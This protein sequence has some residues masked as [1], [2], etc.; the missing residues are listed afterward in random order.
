MVQDCILQKTH[1]FP[2][3][4]K[5][6][7]T[8]MITQSTEIVQPKAV[9]TFIPDFTRPMV[10]SFTYN[11]HLGKIN[12]T[13]SDVVDASTFDARAITLQHSVNRAT[14]RTFTLSSES[15]TYSDNGYLIVVDLD[16]FDL[17]TLKSN[18]GLARDENDTYLTIAAFLI[19]DTNGYDVAP[20]TDGKAIL[21]DMFHF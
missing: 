1:S 14:Q 17:L 2:S 6:S 3:L 20:I 4:Q 11:Q 9:D 21:V 8:L 5:H 16:H 10:L 12:L 19:D 13:F 15:R 18:T 7:M